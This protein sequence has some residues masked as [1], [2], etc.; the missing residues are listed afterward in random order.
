M[1][2][3]GVRLAAGAVTI[4]LGAFAAVQAQKDRQ[5]ASPESWTAATPPSLEQIPEPITGPATAS[6]LSDPDLPPS[7]APTNDSAAPPPV[8]LIQHS[9]PVDSPNPATEA[10]SDAGDAS[11]GGFDA[12]S[13]AFNPSLTGFDPGRPESNDSGEAAST[14]T[15]VAAPTWSLP[16][17]ESPQPAA[18]AQP[19]MTMSL[20]G[21]TASAGDPEA[22]ATAADLPEIQFGEAPAM[23]FAAGAAVAAAAGVNALQTAQGSVPAAE[24][25]S[26]DGGFPNALRSDAASANQ[27][28][29]EDAMQ[30]AAG[31]EFP[32]DAAAGEGAPT[33]NAAINTGENGFTAP[34]GLGQSQGYD[35]QGYG[36]SAGLGAPTGIGAEADAS[37]GFDP[38]PPSQGFASPTQIG[39]AAAI[40]AGATAIGIEATAAQATQPNPPTFNTPPSLAG[41]ASIPAAAFGPGQAPAMQPG[42]N[43]S[44]PGGPD[45]RVASL[46]GRANSL[47]P[48]YPPANL[49]QQPSNLTQQATGGTPFLMDPS[50]TTD[51]PGDRRLEGVQSP[52]IV[53]QKRAPS[54][55][56]V[57]KPAS[58]VIHVQNVGSVAALAVTVHDQVPRGMRLVDASPT[59]AMQGNQLLWQLG[60]MPAGDE[61]TVTM[62]L[63]PEQEGELGSVAR[64]TFEAAASVRTISTRPELKIVQRVPVEKVLIGQQLEIDLEVSNPGTGEATGVMLQEDVPEGLEHPKGRQL[65]NLLGT[66]A[67]GEVRRQVLRLRAVAPGVIQNQIRLVGDDGLT[68]EHTVEVEVVAPELQVALS[69]PSMRFLERQATYAVEI[70]NVGTTAATNIEIAVQLDRG[71]TFVSTENEGQYD[72]SRHTVYWSLAQLPEGGSGKVPLTLLPVEVGDQAI[73]LAVRADLGIVA[74]NE[75]TIA[76]DSFAELSFQITNQGGPIE[77][78]SETLYEVRVQNSGSRN[79]TNVQIQLQLPPGLELITA[80]GDGEARTD[81]QGLVAFP[82]RADLAAGG[83]MTY[84]VRVRGVAPGTHL[85]KAIVTSDQSTVPVTK[86]ESTRVYADR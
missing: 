24:P 40:A 28:R 66:L 20:P 37:G 72:A 70:A 65:D 22:N 63:I 27:L 45:A 68:A 36:P 39:A 47:G 54:E 9:E 84:R 69:G 35:S 61:R 67:P 46:P 5:T 77:V 48:G 10:A 43:Q 19:A 44:Y 85:V 12:Q 49:N 79:D 29:G 23:G 3:F 64:V 34:N 33:G 78:G 38:S 73:N 57:G 52:S 71:L 18:P 60:A 55:V 13:P 6:W 83:D 11:Q 86:E 15:A 59:P 8:R 62:Q 74:K 75:R 58:F 4:L 2:S 81:G 53:I 26:L 7:A 32:A 30:A 82:P 51:S 76:V 56:K 17:Q 16:G 41:Q 1:K 14:D 31:V 21:M 50:L 42:A 25:Q 80:D